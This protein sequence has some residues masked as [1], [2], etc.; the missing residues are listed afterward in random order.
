M[1][2][3]RRFYTLTN[4]RFITRRTRVV[5]SRPRQFHTAI[6][7]F[8]AKQL[9]LR[10]ESAIQSSDYSTAMKTVNELINDDPNN[11]EWYMDKSSIHQQLGQYEQAIQSMNQSI[12]KLPTSKLDKVVDATRFGT[13]GEC[14]VS[15]NKF[16]EAL[17]YLN[18]CIEL[19][20]QEADYPIYLLRA[21]V[22]GQ[23]NRIKDKHNDMMKA[24]SIKPDVEDRER[25]LAWHLHMFSQLYLLIEKQ[26]SRENASKALYHLDQ[27]ISL[28]CPEATVGLY[29]SRAKINMKMKEHSKARTDL[30]KMDT[31]LQK[32]RSKLKEGEYER[33]DVIR[34]V[35]LGELFLTTNEHSKARSELEYALDRGADILQEMNQVNHVEQLLEQCSN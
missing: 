19:L 13:I 31:I 2:M 5:V 21:N 33:L 12:E 34:R 17:P 4:Y 16:E 23:L 1:M 32:I 35:A 27:C 25:D 30:D 15:M 11:Y 14:F 24:M 29:H 6:I 20:G 9:E 26:Y 22:Y 3:M 7:H 8:D 28:Q 10:L 18:K